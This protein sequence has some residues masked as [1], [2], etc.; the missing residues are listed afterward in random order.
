MSGIATA[1]VGTA[2]IGGVASNVASN[3]AGKATDR[4]SQTA[5]DTTREMAAQGRKDVNDNMAIAQQQANQGFQGALDVFG[6]SNPAQMDVFQQG[7]LGAQQALIAG[8]PQIQ[9]AI[10]GGNVD[11]SGLQPFQ[12]Q[13]PDMS[14]MQQTLPS[15]TPQDTAGFAQTGNPAD[16]NGGLGSYTPNNPAFDNVMGPFETNAQLPNGLTFNPYMTGSSF[17]GPSFGGVGSSISGGPS[18]GGLGMRDS[19][20]MADIN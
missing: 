13:Q 18:A 9:N 1:M 17:G 2:I 10:L 20:F 6:Q 7:N 11:L 15:L 4:A 12:V 3:K 19:F 14:F 8:L 5:A 16:M